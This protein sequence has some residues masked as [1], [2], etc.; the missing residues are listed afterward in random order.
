MNTCNIYTN[1]YH[2]FELEDKKHTNENVINTDNH[3]SE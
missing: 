1:A 2:I 3:T